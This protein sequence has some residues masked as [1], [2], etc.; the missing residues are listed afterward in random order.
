[1]AFSTCSTVLSS[2]SWRPVQAYGMRRVRSFRKG[3]QMNGYTALSSSEEAGQSALLLPN[4]CRDDFPIRS[5]MAPMVGASDFAFRCLCRQHGVDLTYTQMIHSKNL[6]GDNTFSKSHL[7]MHERTDRLLDH[8][9]LLPQQ[10]VCLK[11]LQGDRSLPPEL[12]P[13][14]NGPLMVQLAGNSVDMVLRAAQYV[15]DQTDGKVDGF[16][17]NCGCPQGIARKGRYG[18]FLMEEDT[19][20]V[21][22]ILSALRQELPANIA[23]SAKIRLPVTDEM[24]VARMPKLLDTG[25]DFMT[26][27]GRTLHENK[28]KVSAVHTDR[29]R[30]AIETVHKQRPGFPIVANGGVEHMPDVANLQARTG[31]VAVMSSESLLEF[32]NIFSIDTRKLTPRQILEQQIGFARDYLGWC[33]VY[34]PL[35]GVAGNGGSFNAI[36]GHLYKFLHRYLQEFPELRDEMTYMTTL[37]QSIDFLD[38]LEAKYAAVVDIE[39]TGMFSSNPNSSWYRRHRVGNLRV[40]QRDVQLSSGLVSSHDSV[41]LS[42]ERRKQLIKQRIARLKTQRKEKNSVL[43]L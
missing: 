32:P 12:K 4:S 11:G 20:L 40:H 37:Q 8:G 30:L 33:R 1:M 38:R 41:L 7:D 17:L 15:L 31:A 34:P 9:I 3:C 10:E 21:C 22:R 39:L 36:K 23:V 14:T 43:K 16:D 2:C 25:V 24:L 28:T 29:I 13:F 5:V 27:H 26:I 42:T 6:L 19:D 18:A 35:P